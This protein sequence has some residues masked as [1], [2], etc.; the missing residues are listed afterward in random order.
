[1]AQAKEG[2][3]VWVLSG[4]HYAKKQVEKYCVPAMGRKIIDVGS[5]VE[6]ASAYKLSPLS[7]PSFVEV[8]SV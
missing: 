7:L 4:D 6:R 5:N 1:M 2:K 8:Q 3:L